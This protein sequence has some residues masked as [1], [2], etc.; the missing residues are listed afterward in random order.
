MIF[1]PKDTIMNISFLIIAFVVIKNMIKNPV[2]EAIVP[3]EINK[4][5]TIDT[6]GT[7]QPKDIKN[8]KLN[9]FKEN[10]NFLNLLDHIPNS[11]TEDRHHII[12]D[13]LVD[14]ELHITDDFGKI[15][16]GDRNLNVDIN[17]D[18]LKFPYLTDILV[19][20][21]TGDYLEVLVNRT[22]KFKQF[23]K[24][25]NYIV[26][27]IKIKK[28]YSD[29]IINYPLDLKL[30]KKLNEYPSC[31]STVILENPKTKLKQSYKLQNNKTM[32]KLLIS[33]IFE[34]KTFIPNSNDKYK[35][36]KIQ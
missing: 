13:S 20:F 14:I 1:R 7:H 33:K 10:Q 26:Y 21:G 24:Y 18:N 19:K 2:N 31:K 6:I 3:P 35:L 11:K 25:N 32:N 4:V 16:Y 9:E 29:L 5:Y 12:C 15:I 30:D 27:K 23:Y 8:I 34:E 22:E 17:S 28:I 36:I